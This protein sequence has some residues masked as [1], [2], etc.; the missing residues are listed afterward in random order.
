M[1]PG[2][3]FSEEHVDVSP[4]LLYDKTHTWAFMEEDGSVKIGI[5]DFLQRVTGPLT[6]VKMKSP[7][8][9]VK[10]GKKAV[11]IIQEGK[12]LDICAPVS[13]TIQELNPR[14]AKES[15]LLNS[16]PYVDGWIYKI[17]PT[18]WYQEVQF[19][20]MGTSYKRWLKKE[21]QRLKEFLSETFAP[22]DSGH[23]HVLQ[24]GGE[25]R[26]HILKELGPELWEDFQIN[27]LDMSS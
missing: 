27:F 6:R 9:R 8:E 17:K 2:L 26:D 10:K 13:G 20:L 3:A 7:G 23:V 25:I 22:A 24:D 19:L 15:S 5:D 21:F 18:N 14:L 4:G 11:S 1:I 12:Q 16:S